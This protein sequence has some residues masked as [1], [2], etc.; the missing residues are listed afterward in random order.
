[1]FN[2]E[3]QEAL[4][5][6][7]HRNYPEALAHFR[8]G[9]PHPICQVYCCLFQRRGL[10]CEQDST[11][12]VDDDVLARLRE[13]A[14]QETAT[15]TDTRTEAALAL[16]MYHYDSPEHRADVEDWV[17]QA[18]EEKHPEAYYILGRWTMDKKEAELRGVAHDLHL[19]MQ[20]IKHAADHNYTPAQDFLAQ[21]LF[22]GA[23]GEHRDQEAAISLLKKAAGDYDVKAAHIV[24]TTPAISKQLT[25]QELADFQKVAARACPDRL[26]KLR[27]GTVPV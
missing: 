27:A 3:L 24:T 7:R 8:A 18:F 26:G 1:M 19:G 9:Q 16:A 5:K 13:T 23:Y 10:G 12:A 20:W 14:T 21:A 2:Y 6:Y 17:Q 25:A 22:K 11:A 4:E 15:P